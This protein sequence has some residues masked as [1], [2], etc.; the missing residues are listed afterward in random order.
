MRFSGWLD[1]GVHV[2][3]STPLG[4]DIRL[5]GILVGEFNYF[6]VERCWLVVVLTR[7]VLEET[8]DEM[9]SSGTL[10]YWLGSFL[11]HLLASSVFC[12]LIQCDFIWKLHMEWDITLFQMKL[13]CSCI[14]NVV[15]L[16]LGDNNKYFPDLAWVCI[17]YF[18][19]AV[20]LCAGMP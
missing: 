15:K 13:D 1:S 4:W 19:P 17:F 8:A 7:A 16:H 12:I 10:F 9:G 11:L 6:L 5:S 18:F 2:G 20:C 14:G 3:S